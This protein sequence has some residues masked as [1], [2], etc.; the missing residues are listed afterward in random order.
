MRIDQI[1]IDRFW[2][3]VDKK[4]DDECWEWKASRFPNGYSKFWH[5]GENIS[6]HRFSFLLHHGKI[7]KGMFILH[8]CDNKPCINPSHL[9][10]GTPKDNSADMRAKGRSAKGVRIGNS[11]LTDEKVRR[12]RELFATGKYTL[13]AMGTLFGINLTNVH[14]IIHFKIWVHVK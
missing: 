14:R 12:I 7:P 2:A 9:S 3:K 1:V 4:S 11:K 8:S 5:I 6:G 13:K 10:L